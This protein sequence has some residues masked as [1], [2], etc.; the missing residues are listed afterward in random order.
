MVANA[1]YKKCGGKFVTFREVGTVWDREVARGTH[2][3]LDYI[4]VNRGWRNM[5]KDAEADN[6][7]NIETDHS[8]AWSKIIIKLKAV[9]SN[10]IIG[11]KW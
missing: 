2:E 9:K 11:R 4:M 5:S 6:E 1:L 3:Q 8:S 10:K 7:A